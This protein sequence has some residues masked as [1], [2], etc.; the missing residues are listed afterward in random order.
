[1]AICGGPPLPAAVIHHRDNYNDS[2]LSGA[3]IAVGTADAPAG[4]R[5]CH[6][7]EGMDIRTHMI[8]AFLALWETYRGT[9]LILYVSDGIVRGLLREQA[10]NYPGL[11]VRDVVSGARLQA[12]WRSAV[13]AIDEAQAELCGPGECEFVQEKRHLVIA[14]DAS[15]QSRGNTV[16]IGAANSRGNIR[17]SVITAGTVLEGEFAAVGSALRKW[18][19]TADVIDVLT[20][21]RAVATILR[22]DRPKPTG[23]GGGQRGAVVQTLNNLRR[24]ATIRIHWVRGHDGHVL[25]EM[26]HRAAMTARRCHEMN[27]GNQ[28][29]FYCDFRD[30]LQ[31]ELTGMEPAELV[32]G[33]G[34]R[35]RAAA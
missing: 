8:E 27:T 31:E 15:K 5:Q 28:K 22:H 16:G 10:E 29:E 6:V 25:N 35:G 18:G 23:A 14:T 32:P 24:T 1:M 2:T 7:D 34:G 12:A 20:D 30:E 13:C 4:V 9:G 19:H 3:F 21:C 11:I 17:G 33:G 26:A